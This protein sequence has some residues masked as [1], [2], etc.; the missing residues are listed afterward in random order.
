L[1]R[2]FIDLEAF[3]GSNPIAS[4][5]LLFVWILLSSDPQALEI[6]TAPQTISC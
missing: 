1:E 2:I 6:K 5:A 3:H 4:E